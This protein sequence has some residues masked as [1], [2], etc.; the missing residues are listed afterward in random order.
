[1]KKRSAEPKRKI[2]KGRKQQNSKKLEKRNI[3][4]KRERKQQNRKM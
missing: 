3:E 2:F 1:M 4:R